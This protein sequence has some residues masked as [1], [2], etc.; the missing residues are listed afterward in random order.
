MTGLLEVREKL[1]F[2]YG[3]YEIYVAAAIRFFL[4][5]VVFSVIN[6]QIGYMEQLDQPAVVLL[7][8]LACAFLPINA[9][10]VLAC[11]MVLLH[12]YALALEACAI[13]LCVFL[14]LLFMYGKFAPKNGYVAILTAL[15]CF[16]RV[17]QVMPVATGMLKGPSAYLSVLC[18]AVSYYYITGVQQNLVNFTSTEETEGFAKFTAALRIFTG[19]KEMYLVLAAFFITSLVVYAIRRQSID[20]AW[21]IAMFVG[22]A[23]ELVV[24]LVGYLLLDLMDKAVWAAVGIFIS[25]VVSLVLEFFLYNLDYSR[26]ERVQF[27]DDEYYYFVKAVPK[28]FVAK[29]DKKV[30]RITPKKRTT[31]GRRELA[32]ELDIDQDLLE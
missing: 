14:L 32:R 16:F 10:V 23:V 24:L 25:V 15:L 29:K 4:G 13:G 21:R 30:K 19:N 9:M 26:V 31:V 27:E 28:V 7:A 11:G 12:L 18:G 6:S 1:R 8:S 2:F 5:I 17:P 22:N 20:Y 3:K